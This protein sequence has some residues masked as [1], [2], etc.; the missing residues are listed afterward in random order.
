MLAVAALNVELY[1]ILVICVAVFA[2]VLV[3][4]PLRASLLPVSCGMV[5]FRDDTQDV[6]KI[7]CE[8]VILHQIFLLNFGI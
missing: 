3:F 1:A 8:T 4:Y 6:C 5:Y 2:R 7:I